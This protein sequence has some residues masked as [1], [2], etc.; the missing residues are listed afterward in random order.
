[1]EKEAAAPEQV[2]L[3]VPETIK[4]LEEKEAAAPEQVYAED[5]K[6]QK[7]PFPIIPEILPLNRKQ[8]K[9]A[10]FQLKRL[11]K[12]AAASEQVLFKVPE[13][14][15]DLE[16]KEAPAPEQVQLEVPAP[17]KELEEKEPAAPE[18]VQ[19][20][21][22]EPMEDLQEKEAAAP[23]QFQLKVPE[24]MKDLQEMVEDST[25]QLIFRRDNPFPRNQVTVLENKAKPNEAALQKEKLSE[26]KIS[27]VRRKKWISLA[28]NFNY[29]VKRNNPTDLR[30]QCLQKSILPSQ[31]LR[32]R[33][34]QV[35]QRAPEGEQAGRLAT[36]QKAEPSKP[37]DAPL[38]TTS[39]RRILPR[40]I[41]SQPL[42][43]K[44]PEEKEA[45]APEQ[46]QL[47][48]PEPIKDLEEKVEDST[49]QLLLRKDNVI[50]R[51]QVEVLEKKAK[52]NETLQKASGLNLVKELNKLEFQLFLVKVTE[53]KTGHKL[54]HLEEA[55]QVQKEGNRET[56][57]NLVQTIQLQKKSQEDVAMYLAQQR[58]TNDQLQAALTE[59][60]AE[61]NRQQLQR[62]EESDNL[63]QAINTMKCTLEETKVVQRPEKLSLL[64]RFL[65]FFRP[66]GGQETR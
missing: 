7:A 42:A 12:K 52:L 44:C 8:R 54:K 31:S 5:T 3:E 43:A 11:E 16:E 22:P 13:S 33:P 38:S 57:M 62:Q 58:E 24:A 15:N 64:K 4:D 46:V 35:A 47:Q 53:S 51:I 45:A 34:H 40:C 29:P 41:M 23:E 65:R 27:N 17:I 49:H 50:L 56:V 61:N 66:A 6:P 10:A 39:Q 55:L 9:V 28:P 21:V 30:E 26:N 19:L 59:T 32:E 60:L 63:F 37:K 2:Q 48:V 20:E 25:S 18:Q 14:T 1:M 36:R